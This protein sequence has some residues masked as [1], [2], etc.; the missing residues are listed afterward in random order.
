MRN[1]AGPWPPLSP[2]AP[3]TA[4]RA[5]A[6]PPD[7]L[8]PV[9]ILDAYAAH[10]ARLLALPPF[11]VEAAGSPAVRVLL[12]P[13]FDP[14]VAITLVAA[15]DHA[16][17][18]VRTLDRSAWGHLYAMH[19][20]TAADPVRGF[21]EPIVAAEEIEVELDTAAALVARVAVAAAEA[22]ADDGIGLDG[23]PVEGE[24]TDGARTVA[25]KRWSPTRAGDALEVAI[26]DLVELA[27]GSM[28]WQRSRVALEAIA[29]YTQQLTLTPP[30]SPSPPPPRAAARPPPR[31]R[32][33]ARAGC[34]PA[35][36]RSTS[37]LP[38]R[39]PRR[40]RP[41]VALAAARPPTPA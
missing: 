29:R 10:L 39:L 32:L 41:A 3:P 5:P 16:R 28:R 30:R 18:V 4:T 26:V 14:E 17:M 9:D 25:F 20:G 11:T 27:R 36:T 24:V 31:R 12:Q 13:S 34:A 6:P 19:D 33:S 40:A 35:A 23:M 15:P 38:S 7:R 21:V 2:L 22:S 1:V 8:E 37:D